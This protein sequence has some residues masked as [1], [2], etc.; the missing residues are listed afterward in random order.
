MRTRN[1][2]RGGPMELN[3]LG[4]GAVGFDDH[5]CSV[6]QDL[7]HRPGH[8]G[9]IKPDA[10]DGIRSQALCMGAQSLNRFVP[11]LL[12]QLGVYLDFPTSPAPEK[13]ED[14]LAQ[15]SGPDDQ[16]VRY[17]DDFGHVMP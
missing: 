6:R 5:G 13:G 10:N 4:G 15:S 1:S 12:E 7:C 11:D 17:T 14:V 2:V 3:E 8:F 16:S 9:C